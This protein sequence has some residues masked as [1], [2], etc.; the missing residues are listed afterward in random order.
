M[1]NK[2]SKPLEVEAPVA[3]TPAMESWGEAPSRI[4]DDERDGSE[5]V[6][7]SWVFCKAKP[8]AVKHHRSDD[9]ERKRRQALRWRKRSSFIELDCG[10]D[11]FFVSNTYKSIGMADGVGGWKDYGVD[12]SL[13]SNALMENAKRYSETHR[14]ETNPETILS[15]A[16]DRVVSEKKVDAG[17]STAICATL[18]KEGTKHFINV[19]NIGDSGLMVVRNRNI[20]HR[21]H[22]LV[23]SFNAPFQLAVLPKGMRNAFSDRVSDAIRD[24][25]EVQYG[26]VVV[27]GTDGL[28]DNRFNTQIAAD[29]GW[30]GKTE[31]SSMSKI[32]FVGAMLSTVF[33][34][35]EQE[36]DHIDPYRV[37]TRIV[38][39]AYQTALSKDSNSPWADMLRQSGVEGAKG[40]KVDDVTVLLGRITTRDEANMNI[41]W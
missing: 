9:E 26:D 17:S 28:F 13:F 20:L 32:P 41:S 38:H 12:P 40:G 19:A 22:E 23:H 3:A 39:E 6:I 11:S 10:E 37:A 34:Q 14:T 33:A 35:Q 7:Q 30:V 29:A 1:G 4:P 18:T 2:A 5:L 21:V 24:R 15:H 31:I 16:Y 25:I 27:M 36:V 8:A